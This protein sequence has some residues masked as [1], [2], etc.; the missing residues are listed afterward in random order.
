MSQPN[1]DYVDA[2]YEAHGFETI[3]GEHV[4]FTDKEI[5]RDPMMGV[6]VGRYRQDTGELMKT[7]LLEPSVVDHAGYRK[8]RTIRFYRKKREQKLKN[9]KPY[10][11]GR[12]AF[13]NLPT[14]FKDAR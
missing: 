14:Q 7:F 8:G 13:S 9:C 1:P 6:K 5:G 12:D 3:N 2:P 11:P 10:V 4:W